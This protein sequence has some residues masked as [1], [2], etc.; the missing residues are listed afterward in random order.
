[1]NRELKRWR[2]HLNYNYHLAAYECWTDWL[3]DEKI[4]IAKLAEARRLTVHVHF[5][6]LSNRG[7]LA[8]AALDAIDLSDAS[9]DCH[10][11]LQNLRE[12]LEDAVHE[13]KMRNDFRRGTTVT[14]GSSKVRI[15]RGRP[16]V[17]GKPCR[18]GAESGA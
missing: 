7:H 8:L 5:A 11:A 16:Q 10:F 9:A 2:H 15:S 1:M 12:L 4:G 18:E 14:S 6:C 17:Q 13:S 3:I